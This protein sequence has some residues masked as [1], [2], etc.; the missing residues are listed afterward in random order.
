MTTYYNYIPATLNPDMR[1]AE[2]YEDYKGIIPPNF[3]YEGFDLSCSNDPIY[4]WNAHSVLVHRENHVVKYSEN[5][6]L[7]LLL[8]DE[9]G[10]T[11]W[12]DGRTANLIDIDESAIVDTS[13][14]NEYFIEDYD[15]EKSIKRRFKVTLEETSD[16]DDHDYCEL[17]NCFGEKLNTSTAVNITNNTNNIN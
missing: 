8:E 14:S 3:Y 16:M 6:F 7:D 1:E 9:D 17:K 15:L 12:F 4:L 10:G 11:S 2:F 13:P 5:V